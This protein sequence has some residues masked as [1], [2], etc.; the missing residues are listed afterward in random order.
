[1]P[2]LMLVDDDRW[3]LIDLTR[4]LGA[5]CPEFE[6][7]GSYSSAE[8]A[9][10]P[11]ITEKPDVVLADVCMGV[12]SGLDL[13]RLSRAKGSRAVFVII[14]GHDSFEFA[15]QALNM[16]AFHYMLK[17]IDPDE[18]RKVLLRVN[19]ELAGQTA[20][21]DEVEDTFSDILLFIRDNLGTD[22]TLAQLS[23][24]FF[25]NQTYLSEQF[26]QQLGKSFSQ[27]R[28]EMRIARAKKLLTAGKR[29]SEVSEAV[30]FTSDTYFSMLFRQM[31]GI[32]PK[33]YQ[34]SVKR[35]KYRDMI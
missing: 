30:G 7:V 5:T 27:Y 22:L 13:M 14:S 20:T 33:E 8:A 10:E 3:A 18:L 15:Q 9:L 16:H 26:R 1:M 23:K 12:D 6:I 25:I 21:S 24:K 11:I 32:S 35:D 31:E 28:N 17:P 4:I 19:D 2:R 29:V 34:L